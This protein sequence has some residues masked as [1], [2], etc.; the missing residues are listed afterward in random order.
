[1]PC[2]IYNLDYGTAALFLSPH[3]P[4]LASLGLVALTSACMK[5][6]DSAEQATTATG[7]TYPHETNWSVD[8]MKYYA[9]TS[10]V[11]YVSWEKDCTGCHD[12]L[13]KAR[14][15]GNSISCGL[16]C[17]AT[18]STGANAP[19]TDSGA[20]VP[21][22]SISSSSSVPVDGSDLEAGTG[23]HVSDTSSTIEDRLLGGADAKS[24]MPNPSC[25]ACHTL[26]IKQYS[27]F[28]FNAGICETCHTLPTNHAENGAGPVQT[29][30]T[31]ES[32]YRC[33]FRQDYKPNTHAAMVV[34]NTCTNCRDPHTSEH[35]GLP[36]PRRPNCV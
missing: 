19:T 1:M 14:V 29:A 18:T 6:R 35:R 30:R 20:S 36:K 24:S 12:Q 27:H 26:E 4:I 16:S 5:A 31:E 9:S 25:A 11:S 15:L 8:H 23:A 33:H 2:V 3:H 13:P 22:T 32:C 17:H 34:G 28:P 7:V 21:A 10:D